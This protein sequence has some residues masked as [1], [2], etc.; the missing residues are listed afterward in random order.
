MI[1]AA[2]FITSAAGGVTFT[3]FGPA[4]WAI[5]MLGAL[6]AIAYGAL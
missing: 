2:L 1:W 5:Y 3:L 6:A 4:A